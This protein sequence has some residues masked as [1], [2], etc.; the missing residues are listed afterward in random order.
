MAECFPPTKDRKGRRD[1]PA[2]WE[3]RGDWHS[4]GVWWLSGS[5][6]P[7][8]MWRKHALLFLISPPCQPPSLHFPT[9]HLLISFPCLVYCF[10]G[11]LFLSFTPLSSSFSLCSL[12]SHTSVISSLS[13]FFFQSSQQRWVGGVKH[14]ALEIVVPSALQT[15]QTSCAC[16]VYVRVC[17][18]A[19]V[20]FN[21]KNGL[22]FSLGHGLYHLSYWFIVVVLQI[23]KSHLENDS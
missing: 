18:H 20:C 7:L 9:L 5:S 2:T 8:Q 21:M 15:G 1:K 17:V 10:V 4:A 14:C 11:N 23:Y 16:C 13:F 6:P 3:R 12:P 22:S 19:C